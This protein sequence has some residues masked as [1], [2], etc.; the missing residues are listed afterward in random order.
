MIAVVTLRRARLPPRMACR[1]GTCL[2]FKLQ[3]GAL[4]NKF[5]FNFPNASVETYNNLSVADKVSVVFGNAE[6]YRVASLIAKALAERDPL[7]TS[8]VFVEVLTLESLINKRHVECIKGSMYKKNR[9]SGII[10]VYSDGLF[11]DD[12]HVG[13]TVVAEE[14]TIETTANTLAVSIQKLNV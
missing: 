11:R 14:K 5:I 1:G 13:T 2:L 4:I 12:V 10:G 9:F 6:G 3:S 8:L 7:A